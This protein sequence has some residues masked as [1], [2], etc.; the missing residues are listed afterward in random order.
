VGNE[1]EMVLHRREA[2]ARG[3]RIVL[4]EQGKGTAGRLA[5]GKSDELVVEALGVVASGADEVGAQD[6]SNAEKQQRIW[7]RKKMADIFS[8]VGG[9]TEKCC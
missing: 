4:L 1:F 7:G 9:G 5:T 6:Q 8:P 3:I 2:A